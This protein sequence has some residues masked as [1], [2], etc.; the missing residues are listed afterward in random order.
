MYIYIIILQNKIL[1]TKFSWILTKKRR[2][3]KFTGV[4][5]ITTP[6]Y[7]IGAASNSNRWAT[8]LE[9]AVARVPNIA[10]LPLPQL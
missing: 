3:Y 7:R 2:K 6:L 10:H 8:E 9:K 1:S 4:V 5:S